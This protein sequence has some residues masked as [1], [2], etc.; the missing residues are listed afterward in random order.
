MNI[1]EFMS[2]KDEIERLNNQISVLAGFYHGFYSKQ[3]K[4]LK[5]IVGTQKIM[6]SRALARNQSIKDSAQRSVDVLIKLKMDK[7]ITIIDSEIAK[8]C[9]VSKRSVIDARCRIKKGRL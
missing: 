6:R 4:K 5:T 9:F 1:G 8:A 7:K 2:Q 3:I